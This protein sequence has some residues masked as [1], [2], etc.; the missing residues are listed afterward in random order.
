[1]MT[2]TRRRRI[3]TWLAALTLTTVLASGCTASAWRYDA[4][5]GAGV[6]TDAGPVKARNILVVAND[7]GTGVLLGSLAASSAVELTAARITAEPTGETKPAPVDLSVTG[8]IPAGGVLNLESEKVVAKD[9]GLV[10]GQLAQVA[11]LFND[12][13]QI[14]VTTPVMSAEHD[15]YAQAFKGA[16]G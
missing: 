1:M 9:A 6:Q 4:P 14:T 5:S 8:K 15:D 3:G 16:Q 7:E 10:P 13:T 2:P 11:L 12:G